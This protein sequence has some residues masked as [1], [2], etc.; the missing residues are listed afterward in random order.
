[1]LCD[2]QGI[3]VTHIL[4]TAKLDYTPEQEGDLEFFKD[5]VIYLEHR[6]SAGWYYGEPATGGSAGMVPENYIGKPMI[7][8]SNLSFAF[9]A[10]SS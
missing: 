7:L 8:C 1:M 6:E 2:R 4:P 9:I 10:Y 5:E 3:T